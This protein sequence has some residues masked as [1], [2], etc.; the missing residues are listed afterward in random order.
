[1]RYYCI[2]C[3]KEI[4]VAFLKGF[5][6]TPLLSFGQISLLCLRRVYLAMAC[7]LS[8]SWLGQRHDINAILFRIFGHKITD[9]RVCASSSLQ[10]FIF[11]IY[12]RWLLLVEGRGSKTW[13]VFKTRC[14]SVFL[15]LDSLL[16]FCLSRLQC[17]A[18]HLSALI[19]CLC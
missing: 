15:A 7:R 16:K 18:S 9:L 11:V 14:E 13:R 19:A 17:V 2:H 12:T 6:T 5:V 10:I 8:C 3:E 1:M 4:L